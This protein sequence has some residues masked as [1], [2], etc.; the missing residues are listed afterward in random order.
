[1]ATSS[2]TRGLF[3]SVPLVLVAL[4]A[5]ATSVVTPGPSARVIRWLFERDSVK[6]AEEANRH[7]PATGVTETLALGYATHPEVALDVYSPES[8]S[9]PLP[10]L[11]WIH[12]GAWLSGTRGDI[13]PYARILA[14]RGYTVV[15]IDYSIA[16]EHRYP[17]AVTQVNSALAYLAE[18]AAEL[19]IDPDRFVIA[20]DSAGAQLT[21]QIALVITNP[22]YA[23]RLGIVPAIVP[24]RLRGVVLQCGLYDISRMVGV[25]GLV[26]WAFGIAFWA[27]GGERRWATSRAAVEMSSIDFVTAGFPATFI[28]G[29]NG[30]PLTAAQSIPFAAKL[31]GLG[32]SV[33]S[34]FYP[35]EHEPPLP[36]E[37]QFHLDLADARAVL[38]KTVDFLGV[39]T[40]E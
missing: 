26:G 39:V 12:G 22:S 14:A 19:R 20:G 16:P 32:V 30:D 27:Y 21:S 35:D 3:Y 31:S 18:H 29:G 9:G 10:T 34:V 36:H 38:E 1:M 11:V 23:E 17:T 28:S 4:A 8:E 6:T 15:S 24:A 33:T 40:G 5:A 37:Y 7:A 25:P 2:R 13:R